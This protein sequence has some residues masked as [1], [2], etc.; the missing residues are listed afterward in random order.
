MV[1]QYESNQKLSKHVEYIT[2]IKTI[3]IKHEKILI[4]ITYS[5]KLVEWNLV[6]LLK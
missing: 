5:I 6:N 3:E 1:R 4:N 2:N